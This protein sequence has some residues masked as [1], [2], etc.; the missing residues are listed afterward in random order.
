MEWE[1][2]AINLGVLYW[3]PTYVKFGSF[4]TTWTQRGQLT[5]LQS[6]PNQDQLTPVTHQFFPP[7]FPSK[8]F[9]PQPKGSTWRHL[10]LSQGAWR[11]IN[12]SLNR[13]SAESG[14]KPASNGPAKLRI[15]SKIYS[16]VKFKLSILSEVYLILAGQ[17]KRQWVMGPPFGPYQANRAQHQNFGPHKPTHHTRGNIS[18]PAGTNN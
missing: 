4:H 6:R 3:I 11:D 5:H 8:I 17:S 18:C 10:R 16:Y 14:K 1:E 12:W 9:P 13:F 7:K 15:A 2:L